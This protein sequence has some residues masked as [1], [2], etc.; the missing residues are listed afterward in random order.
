M[1]SYL[2]TTIVGF[3]RRALPVFAFSLSVLIV[4]A[5]PG[6]QAP[7][8]PPDQSGG[9]KPEEVIKLSP[10]EVVSDTRGYFSANTMSGTRFNTKLQDLGSSIT[11]MTK[12]QM[13][14]FAMLDI[15]DVF[16]Y[17]VGTEG[18]GTYS[19]F[20]MNRNGELTDNVSL[21]PAQA[22]RVRGISAANISYGN[23]ETAGRRPLD[24]LI[25]DGVEI[26]RGPNA[27]VF[28]LGQ[29]SG[30]VNQ[31]PASANLSRHRATVQLRMD[32]WDGY[33]TSLDVNRY[34][35]KDKLGIRFSIL[36]Q[37]E[38][39]VRKPSGVDTVAYNGFIKYQPFKNTSLNAS[40][41]Y[42]KSY[43]NR[44]N[45]TP[46]R[47]Y[48]SYWIESG[49]PGWD[50]IAQKVVMPDGTTY[51]PFVNDDFL[52]TPVGYAFNRSGGQFQRS[53][54]FIDPDGIFYWTA[55]TN[56]TGSTPAAN[57]GSGATVN[58]NGTPRPQGFI[59]LLGSSPGPTGRSGRYSDQPLFN[60]VRSV[61][62]RDIYDYE[63]INLAAPNYIW[64]ESKTYY[65]TIDQFFLNT[66]SQ[67]LAA[68]FGF[69]REDTD[70]FR[71]V[72]IGD[73]GTGGQNGQL[74]VD[75]NK[76][77]LD[78]TSNPNFGRTY[79]G[80]GEPIYSY[81]PAKWDTYRGQ[82]AYRYD[83][84][85]SNGWRKWLGVHQ[86]S[87]YYEYKYRIERKYS[88]RE[89]IASEHPWLQVGQPGVV[90]NYARANQA[91]IAGGPQAGPNII[92]PF[93]RFYVGD[94]EGA[95]VDYAPGP[96]IPGAYDFLWGTIGNWRREQA[97]LQ[98]LATTN[99][100][101]GPNNLKRIIKTA[102]GVLHS[103]FLDGKLVT[104]FGIR[105]DKVFAMQGATPQLLVNNNTEHDFERD[106]H[107]ETAYRPSR[108]KT[109][110]AQ[111]VV[112]PLRDLAAAN[113]WA[114]QG[115][116]LTRF[117][118]ELIRGAAF[119]YNKSDSFIPAPPAFDLFLRP[120]PNQSGEGRDMGVWFNLFSGK[121]VVRVNHY[122]NKAVN[123]RDGDANTIAQRT[124]RLD[125]DV[126]TDR[127]RLYARAKDWYTLLNPTWS[128]AQVEAA[129]FDTMKIDKATYEAL[130]ENFQAG[131]IAAT[132]D[133]VAA[134]TEVELNFNPTRYWTVTANFEEKRSKNE[135]VS[136]TVQDWINLRMPVWTTIV[137]PNFDPNLTAGPAE[138]TGW[139]PTPDNPNH[140]WWLHRYGSSSQSP[141]EN[142][143][144]NVEAP[145]SIIRETEGKSR[146]QVRRYAG[147]LSTSFQLAA[148]TDNRI[149][150]RLSIGGAVR[151][152]SKGAIGYYGVEQYPARITRL[153]PNRPIYD[154]EHYYFDA[155]IAYRTRLFNDK[156]SA[157]FQLNVRNLQES[158]RLQPVG[159]FPNGEIHSY[160]IVDPRQFILTAT[161]DL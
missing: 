28:G 64:D 120:L 91:S 67:F 141:A 10:F 49:R 59:R 106:N 139:L 44:P 17:T 16:L 129:I 23:F 90:A 58:T 153:D 42:N 33:R 137:D 80:V 25:L 37:R 118:G 46:P 47:D 103:Q 54:V 94:A 154:K 53:N 73:A 116:G 76:F 146:P 143:A 140:L 14:D 157:K 39:F 2:R 21:N 112:R 131:T 86:L 26:S 142:Y 7:A 88:Y 148:I 107:W 95:N 114:Q 130:V 8:Q 38:G 78:G 84:T 1:T 151:Y 79:I 119:T 121:L 65:V 102:G 115:T 134:G 132:N 13:S 19:D 34:L 156:V 63:S 60:S 18:T 66:P 160:R 57:T 104:T 32:D 61:M 89:A 128:A 124:L 136:S 149:L 87:P 97:S 81:Y 50:P 72:P 152:E 48:V 96:I 161:F 56:N 138:S 111:F 69:F 110:T 123:A 71:K 41:Q 51:G 30:T 74:W 22:N 70:R 24:P 75:V 20:A 145:W 35:I 3:L 55:P 82:L 108:G 27:N 93:Y 9:E 92:R 150:Q 12:E 40:Y 85:Q 98:T 144:V 122:E 4:P 52:N 45:F 29:P 100:T 68:Q 43:G 155:F 5:A 62:S 159:A 158:G 117:F 101:G 11:V 133:I 126:T 83:F 36:K 135:N 125:L 99:N 105:D 77:N 6:Q 147:R 113:R 109:K 127:H 15:N 31:V